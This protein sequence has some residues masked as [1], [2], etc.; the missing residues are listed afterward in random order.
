MA[1]YILVPGGWHGG[2]ACDAPQTDRK[3]DFRIGLALVKS[4]VELHGGEVTA[5]SD[6]PGAGSRFRVLLLLAKCTL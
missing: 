1:T 2:W 5:H 4:I 6:G 3:V